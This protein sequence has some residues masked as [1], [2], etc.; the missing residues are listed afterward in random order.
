MK[1]FARS[2]AAVSAESKPDHAPLEL[3]RFLPYRLSILSNTVSQAIADDYQQ[4]YDLTVTEWRVMAVLARF[5]GLSAREV[6]ERTAMDKVAVSRA[7]ARLVEAGRVH[8]GTHDGDKRRSVLS[9]SEN[10]W[11]VHDEVAPMAR[12]RE[13]EVL[14]KLDDEEQAWLTR[15]LDKL[16][17]L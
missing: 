13:R 17:P 15:I 2:G 10:G 12:A 16:Q 4:R 6:A 11:Q 1:P 7:L 5:D 3:E 8:R 14:A 9:L